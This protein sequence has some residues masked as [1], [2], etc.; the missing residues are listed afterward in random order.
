MKKA[1][2]IGYGWLGSRIAKTLSK[3]FEI[4]TT[5]TTLDKEEDLFS[6]GF[7]PYVINFPDYLLAEKHSPWQVLNDLDVLIITIPLSGKNCCASSLYNRIQN[8][9]SFI[10]DFKGQL[11]LM[12]STGV[13][14]DL[15]QEL[16]EEDMSSDNVPGERMFKNR[17][18][19]V[20]IL[21]LAGLM[22]DNRLLSNYKVSN[23]NLFVNHIH[24]ADICSVIEKMIKQ[25]SQ[26]KI[27]NVAAPLHPTKSEVI[28]IQKN[29]ESSDE[30]GEPGGKRI[31][32]AKLISELDFEFKYPDPRYFHQVN[33]T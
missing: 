3:D 23:V 28:T 22:G 25:Q 15:N 13:Y 19:K 18:P 1:G 24:Y 4:H 30:I 26:S 14:A 32:S 8:L 16:T 5:T 7:H 6:K 9:F 29:I 31:S 21:R 11:F 2:I 17:Y 10:D 27:Y 33:P 12:S 20:N